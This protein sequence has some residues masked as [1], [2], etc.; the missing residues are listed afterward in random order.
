MQHEYPSAV[1][2]SPQAAVVADGSG[3]LY[4]IP[5]RDNNG[6]GSEPVGVFTLPSGVPFRLH[7]LHRASP[8]TVILLLSSRYYSEDFQKNKPGSVAFDIWAVKVD[9]FSL[10]STGITESRPFEVL[11]HRRGEDV[12]VYTT[13]VDKLNAHLIIGGSSYRDPDTLQKLASTYHEPTPD[14]MAPIPRANEMLDA[15]PSDQEKK[16][17]PYS[18]TQSSDS[19]T[20]AFPL[21]ST[22]PKTS[23]KVFF[24]TQTLTVHVDNNNKNDELTTTLPVPIPIPHYSAKALWADINPS[25]SFW[26]WDREGE[27]KWGLLT[28]YM[29]KKHDGTRWMHV[30]NPSPHRPAA[31]TTTTTSPLP[32]LK[33]SESDAEMEVPETLDPSELWHIRESLEKYTSAIRDGED[34]SGLG[35]GK[36]L[37]S[38][39]DGE[40]D[41]EVD[42]NV[43][44]RVCLTWVREGGMDTNEVAAASEE[45][46]ADH[47][48]EERFVHLLSTPL[49][50]SLDI[51]KDD[52]SLIL[53]H[54]LDG[55]V[56]TLQ[57]SSKANNNTPSTPQWIHTS[58]YSALSFVLASKQDTRFTHHLHPFSDSPSGGAVL[59]FE[60]GSSRGRGGNLY[61]YRSVPT[62][63]E[64]WAKQAVLKVDDGLG[65]ALLGVG[66]IRGKGGEKMVVCLTEGELVVIQGI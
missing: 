14:E 50:G 3:L 15:S 58:T 38:L 25:S 23:I 7:H 10:R 45:A 51:D 12:P 22:T 6:V 17:Y 11:W 56:F 33:G 36:G 5:I 41:E 4:V 66:C 13:F 62:S 64:K 40:I 1:F 60:G 47:V 20:V 61:I 44:R 43:G 27:K 31:A 42:A 53:K 65:G 34:A 48:E 19:V 46:T 9:L 16:F 39:A 30:F 55:T 59:A 21:P 52:V 32:D 57:S 49:P 63:K 26:T 28:L 24:T 37:S 2:I 35:L 8:T 54:D 18:W 29:E